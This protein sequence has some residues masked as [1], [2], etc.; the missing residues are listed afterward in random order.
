MPGRIRSVEEVFVNVPISVYRPHKKNEKAERTLEVFGD[1][2]N[3]FT[4]LWSCRRKGFHE[5]ARLNLCYHWP[6]L[7]T[8][9]VVANAVDCC[10]AS[11]P[12]PAKAAQ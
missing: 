8:R 11:F 9:I 5:E 6:R 7:K 1:S 3:L 10:I 4:L 12:K 2:I